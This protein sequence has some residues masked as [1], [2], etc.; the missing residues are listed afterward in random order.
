MGNENTRP[1]DDPNM[2]FQDKLTHDN[3]EKLYLL[4]LK[5]L[6]KPLPNIVELRA[7]VKR[8]YLESVGSLD[9]S[10]KFLPI[11]FKI[12][13]E[14]YFEGL[15]AKTIAEKRST[16]QI[17][18]SYDYKDDGTGATCSASR[19]CV[20]TIKLNKQIFL[21]ED[22]FAIR[23]RRHVGD[24][25]CED[26]FDCLLLTFLHEVTHLVFY[27]ISD[28]DKV[29]RPGIVYEQEPFVPHALV[30]RYIP[31]T[32][33]VGHSESFKK[34]VLHAFGLTTI[35]HG[36]TKELAEYEAELSRKR[37]EHEAFMEEHRIIMERSK[38]ALDR[39]AELERKLK[40]SADR[41]LAERKSAE[42]RRKL[43]LERHSAER[44]SAERK[45]AERRKEN[46]E[47]HSAERKSVERRQQESE[48][49]HSA[50]RKSAERKRSSY[51][52]TQTQK[53]RKRTV[54]EYESYNDKAKALIR[55]T[56]L[57]QGHKDCRRN[58][59]FDAMCKC[60]RLKTS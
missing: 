34:L 55:S 3:E 23:K 47:R 24:V 9:I 15:L 44:H 40:E 39:Y 57:A 50:E 1:T 13:D 7:L 17:I 14:T 22:L 36:L 18:Y 33:R 16:I 20:Y 12:I 21:D 19:R 49:R 45:S 56:C 43:S 27:L 26:L 58:E 25:H 11:L 32:G 41:H 4:V 28:G 59:S 46:A 51:K 37:K 6:A 48:E 60:K 30:S 35:F 52:T 38:K 54:T 10:E 5:I 53:S 8:L 29:E 2:F 42:R 31:K